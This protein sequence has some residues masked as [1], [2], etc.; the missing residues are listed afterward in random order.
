MIIRLNISRKNDLL[1]IFI[2]LFLGVI[3]LTLR[4]EIASDIEI[5]LLGVALGF[6]ILTIPVG[7]ILLLNLLLLVSTILCTLYLPF[8]YELLGDLVSDLMLF[9]SISALPGKSGYIVLVI[10]PFLWINIPY[11]IASA[12]SKVIGGK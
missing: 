2:S 7:R 12:L 8:F 4:E 5:T 1:S 9:P 11:L 3:P 10:F 6:Y